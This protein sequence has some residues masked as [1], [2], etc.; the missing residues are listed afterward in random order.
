MFKN[1][2]WREALMS[3]FIGACVAFLTTFFEGM[4][5][6]LQGAENN[7]FAGVA[8]TASYLSRVWHHIV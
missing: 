8:A 5:D 2:D 7:V 1:I 6:I 3:V 4:L